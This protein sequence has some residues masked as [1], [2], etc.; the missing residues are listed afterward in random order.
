[1]SDEAEYALPVTSPTHPSFHHQQNNLY[2]SIRDQSV[3]SRSMRL[4]DLTVSVPYSSPPA[5]VAN[6]KLPAP[7]WASLEFKFYYL[8][9]VILLPIMAYIPISLSSCKL[10]S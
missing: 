6:Q 5:A 10:N 2:H 7:R 4:V 1:M 9:A 8:V 3:F